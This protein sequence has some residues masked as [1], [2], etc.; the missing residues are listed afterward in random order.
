M[1]DLADSGRVI[2]PITL[3]E[4][5]D[6][7]KELETIGGC[8]YISEL[9]DGVPDRPSIEHYVKIVRGVAD[10]RHVSKLLEQGQRLADDPSVPTMALADLCGELAQ[11]SVGGENLAPRFSEDWLALRFSRKYTDDLRY[12]HHWGQRLRW[13]E[14]RWLQDSTLH[15][16][17]L[18]RGICRAASAECSDS[19]KMSVGKLASKV[20]SA[21]VE[22]LAAADRRHAATVEQWDCDPWLL[23]TP[24]GTI[25]LH[26]GQIREHRRTDYLTKITAAGPSG[27]CVL[28]LRFLDRVTGTPNCNRFCSE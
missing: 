7:H 12:V 20:T 16:F 2:D 8:A 11:I 4:E 14:L 26:T 22:R 21:A 24:T 28:W 6:R 5:L 25:D 9:L 1:V 23:N 15:V 18:A 17:D 10:R 27:D 13:D 3:A 19:E